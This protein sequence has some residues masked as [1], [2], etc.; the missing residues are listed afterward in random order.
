MKFHYLFDIEIQEGRIAGRSVLITGDAGS[1]KTA[2][3]MAMARALGSDTPFESITA[4]E[5]WSSIER[6]WTYKSTI[7]QIFSLEFSKTEALLQSLR[8]AIGVRIKEE[9]EV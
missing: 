8:K 6:A 9:T 3:A 1:G 7:F 4:S 5:V 2:I